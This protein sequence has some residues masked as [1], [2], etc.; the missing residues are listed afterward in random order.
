MKWI[1]KHP[2]WTMFFGLVLAYFLVFVAICLYDY[3]YVETYLSSQIAQYVVGFAG[4]V[5]LP[6]WNIR[7]KG[8]SL[9]NMFWLVLV[10]FLG[11][12]WWIIMCLRA[13]E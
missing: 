8:R 11:A 4:F 6:A 7:K 13:K 10:P 12:G 1:G 9:F 2:N 3:G 5:L